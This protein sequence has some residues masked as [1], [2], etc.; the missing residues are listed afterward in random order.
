MASTASASSHSVTPVRSLRTS[1]ASGVIRTTRERQRTG[2][3][4]S[5]TRFMM[6][7]STQA[8]T[9]GSNPSKRC[10]SVTRA[11]ARQHS[12]AASTLELPPPITITRWRQ[13]RWPSVK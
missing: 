7:G 9:L 11:P 3:L 10:T 1:T 6:S 12:R 5:F 8:L 13:Y 4:P 2:M